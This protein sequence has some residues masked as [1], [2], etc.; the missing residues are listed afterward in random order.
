MTPNKMIQWKVLFLKINLPSGEFAIIHNYLLLKTQYTELNINYYYYNA[1]TYYTT[2]TLNFLLFFIIKTLQNARK[3]KS[4]F[5]KNRAKNS[6]KCGFMK[7][8]LSRVF[9]KMYVINE[10]GL[11]RKNM[12]LSDQVSS[13]QVFQLLFLIYVYN[14]H[15]CKQSSIYMKIIQHL[16]QF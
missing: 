13:V 6:N 2:T 8:N 9:K 15:S 1:H 16:L 12:N 14:Y 10:N 5:T 3:K 7:C 11:G 4:I